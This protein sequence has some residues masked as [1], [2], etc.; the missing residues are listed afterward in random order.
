[1]LDYTY[2]VVF[3][4]PVSL[5]VIYS[6]RRG[7]KWLAVYF[8]NAPLTFVTDK[9]ICFSVLSIFAAKSC[10]AV[11][12]EKNFSIVKHFCNSDFT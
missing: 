6:S 11:W 10:F 8:Q 4:K 7:M 1:V 2:A 5:V 9:E 12:E 3:E